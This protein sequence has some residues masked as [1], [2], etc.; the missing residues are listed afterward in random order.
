MFAGKTQV[1]QRAD[2]SGRTAAAACLSR[3]GK[4]SLVAHWRVGGWI[5][6]FQAKLSDLLIK[7]KQWLVL[8]FTPLRRDE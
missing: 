5:L 7:E 2:S 3:A 8:L 4:N 6:G 1:E